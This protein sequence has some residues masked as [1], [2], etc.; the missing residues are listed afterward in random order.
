MMYSSM[1]AYIV[2]ANVG[3]SSGAVAMSTFF[4]GILAFTSLE[5]VVPMQVCHRS[6]I[7]NVTVYTSLKKGTFG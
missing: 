7:L 1:L 2:D 6:S 5:T 4:R 3:R